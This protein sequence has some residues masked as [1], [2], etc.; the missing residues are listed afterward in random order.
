LR[1][2]EL[3]ARY[4]F[5]KI[6]GISFYDKNILDEPRAHELDVVFWN[7]QNQSPLPFLDPAIIVEC[8]NTGRPVGSNAVGWFVRKLQD[9]GGNHGI[10]IAL[11]GITGARGRTSNAHSEVLN[12]M[13]RDRIKILLVTRADITTLTTTDDL[14]SLLREKYMQLTVRRTVM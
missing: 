2:S 13:M 7:L 3:L 14:V 6:K 4:L 1:T 8:K 10:L 5:E 12:A 9:R 11:S